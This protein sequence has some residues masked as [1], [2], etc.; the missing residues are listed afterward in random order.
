[1]AANGIK[2]VSCKIPH[3]K[4]ASSPHSLG[5]RKNRTA[6]KLARH[7][8]HTQSQRNR[9]VLERRCGGSYRTERGQRLGDA[10]QFSQ[11]ER[12]VECL[13]IAHRQPCRRPAGFG[14]NRHA[15]VEPPA[16]AEAPGG[17]VDWYH[18]YHSA[19]SDAHHALAIMM[20]TRPDG[21]GS[22][23]RRKAM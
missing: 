8:Y 10:C 2:T 4:K 23:S 7:A 1:M 12:D 15:A 18:A 22:N 13:D 5:R 14:N 17:R 16:R 9:R 3:S 20:L 11:G 21:A 19:C 6:G